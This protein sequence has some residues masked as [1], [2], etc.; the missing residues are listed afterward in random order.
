MIQILRLGAISLVVTVASVAA[1]AQTTVSVDKPWS[2]AQMAGRNG[3]VY[4]TLTGKDGGD[5]LIAASSP[6]ASRVELH[7]TVMDEGVMKMREVKDLPIPAGG[8]AALQPGGLH[9]MLMNLKQP[10]K[11][12]ETVSVTL[13]FEK[14]GAVTAQA[15]VAKA[16]AAGPDAGHGHHGHR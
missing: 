11:E 5:R 10:L 3:V 7:E 16:G 1:L 13:V 15:V 9:L 6:I 8:T 12:G 4:L 2:R 14:A